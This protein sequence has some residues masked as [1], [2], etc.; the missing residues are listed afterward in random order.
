MASVCETGS[1]SRMDTTFSIPT[2]NT[3]RL[4]LRALR[5]EDLDA[6]AATQA[7]PE[8][9]RFLVDGRTHT[10]TEVW[11][12]MATYLGGWSLQGYGMWACETAE[13]DLFVGSVGISSSRRRRAPRIVGSGGIRVRAAP[14]LRERADYQP[15]SQCSSRP[16]AVGRC[17]LLTKAWLGGRASETSGHNAFYS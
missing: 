7:D 10:R 3:E 13:G 14:P 8:V 15:C 4:R 1:S 5:A 16:R 9:M 6:Y 17:Q 12:T 11:R 2:I